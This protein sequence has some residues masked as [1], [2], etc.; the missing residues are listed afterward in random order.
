MDREQVKSIDNDK[1]D[2]LLHG[3]YTPCTCWPLSA[4]AA[5]SDGILQ[6]HWP[7]APSI[8]V[9]G[10]AVCCNA[11]SLEQDSSSCPVRWVHFYSYFTGFFKAHLSLL[12]ERLKL[13]STLSFSFPLSSPSPPSKLLRSVCHNC[14]SVFN[15][16]ITFSSMGTKQSV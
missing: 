1:S 14:N 15:C 6:P 16:V 11:L 10:S 3:T 7:Y 5:T 13:T 2:S 9:P 4:S 12:Q 8:S